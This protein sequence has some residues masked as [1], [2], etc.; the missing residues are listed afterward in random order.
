MKGN[1]PLT[2][3]F[4]EIMEGS[5]LESGGEVGSL[6]KEEII[7]GDKAPGNGVNDSSVAG[8]SD[9]VLIA[10]EVDGN[11]VIENIAEEKKADK[12][13]VSEGGSV[14]IFRLFA[15]ADAVDYLLMFIGL[16][17]AAAHGCA[18]PVFF[19]FFGNLLDGFGA[20]VNNP[21]K[22]ADVVSKV[23]CMNSGGKL[24]VS[25]LHSRVLIGLSV[26]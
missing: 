2:T 7:S 22:A 15:F 26:S 9:G 12:D 20:N 4:V 24:R 11:V 8:S 25:A 19:L 21:I 14:S 10:K 18:L 1:S 17:G 23:S 16:A 3:N 6:Q 13:V 5:K